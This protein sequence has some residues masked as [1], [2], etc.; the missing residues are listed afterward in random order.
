MPWSVE[1]LADAGLIQLTAEGRMLRDDAI[2]QTRKTF[3]LGMELDIHDYLIDCSLAEY[4]LEAL[5][6]YMLPRIYRMLDVPTRSRLAVIGP[7]S[8]HKAELYRYYEVVCAE[9][10]Y[11][12]RVFA[13][14]QAAVAWLKA[15]RAA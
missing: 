8:G 4:E 13:E 14:R 6:V 2:E 7:L 9:H 12:A 10:C 1:H 3:G 15:Q 5:D 11:T